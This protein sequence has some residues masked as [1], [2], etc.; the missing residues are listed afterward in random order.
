M[1][2]RS[3]TDGGQDTVPYAPHAQHVPYAPLAP[4]ALFAPVD[5]MAPTALAGSREIAGLH[6]EASLHVA[7]FHAG[8]GCKMA[9]RMNSGRIP[10]VEPGL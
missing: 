6:C 10:Q 3:H 5:P 1:E 4:L 8:R 9:P 2:A 7:S